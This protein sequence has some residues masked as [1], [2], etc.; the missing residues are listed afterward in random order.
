MDFEIKLEKNGIN[1]S[2]F[3]DGNLI[4][5][6]GPYRKSMK[7]SA[8]TI[9]EDILSLSLDKGVIIEDA[10]ELAA[11]I[12]NEILN[13][14]GSFFIN[15]S[16]LAF[17]GDGVRIQILNEDGARVPAS[18]LFYRWEDEFII[19]EI[20]YAH[21]KVE[22]RVKRR[23]R[24]EVKEYE[25]IIPVL[26]WARYRDGE[27][28]ERDLKPYQLARK[29]EVQN[30]PVMVELKTR[31]TGTMETLMSL[32]AA[33]KFLRGSEA[34]TWRE[35]FSKIKAMHQKFVNFNWDP[36]LYDVVSCWDLG[37]YFV[38]IFSTYPFL[39]PYGS[40]GC[41]KTRLL[42]TS[43]YL[44]RHGFIVTD[45]SDA[46]I[47]RTAEA[48][49]PSM[50]IDESLLGRHAWKLIRTAFKKGF[51]VPRIEKTSRE[52]F[53]LALFETYTPV[54][55]ASTE[56]PSELGGHAAD[57]ARAL[58][59]FMQKAPDPVGRD[60][61]EWDFADLRDEL[62]LLRLSKADDVL[63][64]LSEVEREDL[65]LYGHE[66]EVWLP[67]FTIAKLVGEDVYE[68]V[69]KYARELGAIKSEFEYQEEKIII[70]ALTRLLDEAKKEATEF[71][72]TELQ[73]YIRYELEDRGEYEENIFKKKW[74]PQRIGRL[75]TRMS[76]FKR[77]T[78][79]KRMY[80]I[81]KEGLKKLKKR[82][83]PENGD[84]SDGSDGNFKRDNINQTHE[85]KLV[86]EKNNIYPLK[87]AV[88]NVTNVTPKDEKPDSEDGF[89]VKEDE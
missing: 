33:Q 80:M 47:Y 36:K 56:R 15:D 66:R 42:L 72:A 14:Y 35:A 24:E 82:Y 37:T 32:D 60:P 55:F 74:T 10:G 44:S 59:I 23:G 76:I 8:K 19:G 39:Y 67:L 57:E 38:E 16:E 5:E 18:Q 21:A 25:T 6:L 7:I 17:Q 28:V 46:T 73:V 3:E 77:R 63:K 84:G 53:I 12:Y 27:I 26:V 29:L 31:Y 83:E 2:L 20:T 22:K 71:T 81:S 13:R 75:L 89:K 51:K 64:A 69:R 61:D 40:Q 86:A 50:G 11:K 49:R 9:A 62:Y 54:A 45:P 41:G 85:K 79:K 43:I 30:R 34:P 4:G 48:F 70:G 88:T 87:N 58:F 78:G 52:E 1:I 68:N 65:K